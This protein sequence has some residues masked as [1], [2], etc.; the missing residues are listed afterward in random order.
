MTLHDVL[1][2]MLVDKMKL[3]SI[4]PQQN[5]KVEF[6]DDF[7]VAIRKNKSL[8]QEYEPPKKKRK[9]TYSMSM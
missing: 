4:K 6:V 1:I 3:S 8:E 7:K 9:I 5:R 2:D